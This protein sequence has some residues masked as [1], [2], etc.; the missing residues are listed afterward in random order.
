MY[1]FLA[2]LA[3]WNVWTAGK[4]PN[5]EE[6]GI[7]MVWNYTI[8]STIIGFSPGLNELDSY[9]TININECGEFIKLHNN[10]YEWYV[11]VQRLFI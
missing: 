6:E 2:T 8:D 1:Y 9:L 4:Y 10:I 11:S 5:N 7:W 3:T